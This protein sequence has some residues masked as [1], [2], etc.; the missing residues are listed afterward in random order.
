MESSR[1]REKVPYVKKKFNILSI[2]RCPFSGGG[3]RNKEMKKAIL[4]VLNILSI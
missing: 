3:E 2:I 1:S 4:L